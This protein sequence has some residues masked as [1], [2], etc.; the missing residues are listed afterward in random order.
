M[1]VPYIP[2]GYHTATPYLVIKGAAAAIEFYKIVFGATE[3]F[4]MPGPG[5]SIMHAEIKIGDSIIMLGE[6]MP[7]W[8]SSS[9]STLGGSPVGICL[10]FP[11]VDARV[12]LALKNGATEKR[13]VKDQFYGDRSGTIAD[14][15]GHLWTIATHIEDVPQAEM[16][17]RFEAEM[18]KMAG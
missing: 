3:L 14:P 2:T 13:P 4:R 10:Y 11:D 18:K 6:E 15:Y 5:G 7:A 16:S 17:R 1:S 8:G 9:P 12:A